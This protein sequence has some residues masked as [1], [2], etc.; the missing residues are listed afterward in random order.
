MV[1]DG[2]AAYTDRFHELARLVPHLVTP[3]SKKVERYVYGLVS[4]IRGMM[5]ATKPKTIQK[6]M[7]LAGSLTDEA[8]R[9]GSI[10][11]NPEKR[12]DGGEPSKDRNVRDDN[13][14]TRTGNAFATTTNPRPGENHQNQVVAVNGGQSR[15]NQ[16]NQARSRAFMLG[17]EEARQDLNIV[18][19]TFTLNDHYA[20]TLFDSGADYSF[21]STTF[22]P[23]LDIEPSDLGFSY[24][25][26]IASGHLV[27]IY[28][29]I[30]GCKLEIEGHVFDINLIPFGIRIPQLDGKMLRVLGERPEEKVRQLMSPKVK[31]RKQEEIMVVRDFPKVFSDDL[32]RLP[33]VWEIEFRIE[34]VHGAMLVA[35]SPYRLAPSEMEELSSQ[36]KELQDK[37]LGSGYH[38]LRVHEDDIPKTAFRTRYRHFKFTIMP[39]GLTNAPAIFMDSMNRVCRLYLDKFVI[40]FIDDILIYSKT[41]KEHEEHLGLFLRHVINGDGIH[42]DPSKIEVVKSWEAPR[43]PFEVCSFLSLAG[44]TFYWG[45]EQEN[46]FQTLKS[47]LCDAPVLA[48]L[49]GPKDFVVYCDASGLGLGCVLMQRGKVIAY[50]SRQLKIYEKNY[51]THDLE[52]GAIKELNMRQHRWIELF[53]DYDCEIRYHLGKANEVA[54]ALSRKERVKPKR[55]RSMNITLQSS[56]EGKILA[57]QEEADDESAGLQRGLDETIERMSDG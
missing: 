7:Q 46:A 51:T 27:E 42:V 32:S 10:K 16:G 52:L 6:D 17:V 11:K 43:T 55:I 28:K 8:L 23:L 48:L 25:I 53:S 38:Q 29:V 54:D 40:A 14:R 5:A 41:R 33:P 18:M 50:A 15:G 56:I 22:I 57:A 34:L 21:V 20:T 49:D 12:G 3:E 30:K 26:E 19:S 31:E 35:K 1:G 44:K 37:D 9:S 45:E 24:E 39:F 36:L 47:K 13:K 4:Q 2:H